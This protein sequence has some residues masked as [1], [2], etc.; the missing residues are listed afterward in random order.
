MTQQQ[1][2]RHSLNSLIDRNEVIRAY[3]WPFTA[4]GPHPFY[5]LVRRMIIE[6]EDYIEEGEFEAAISACRV[7][8]STLTALEDLYAHSILEV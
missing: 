7:G 8:Q 2:A 5:I 3:D 6:A 4:R 1:T